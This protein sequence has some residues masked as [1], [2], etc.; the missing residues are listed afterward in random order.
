MV[1][2]IPNPTAAWNPGVSNPGVNGQNRV[3]DAFAGLMPQAFT[4]ATAV[5]G[6]ATP[7]QNLS[8]EFVTPNAYN[9]GVAFPQTYNPFGVVPTIHPFAANPFVNPS[10]S[11]ATIAQQ[12]A[13]YQNPY[14]V[15]PFLSAFSH[16]FSHPMMTGIANPMSIGFGSY[17]TIPTPISYMQP[18]IAAAFPQNLTTWPTFAGIPMF[19]PQAISSWSNP[20]IA[21]TT[22]FNVTPFQG[23]THPLTQ[24]LL[25]T[26]PNTVGTI[27]TNVLPNITPTI[28][29]IPQVGLNTCLA[30][31]NGIPQ[32][33]GY[34]PTFNPFAC[35]PWSGNPVWP[36]RHMG[37]SL[38]IPFGSSGWHLGQP[39]HFASNN[40][41][42]A[43]TINPY[44]PY[45]ANNILTNPW[46]ANAGSPYNT[47]MNPFAPN[48]PTGPTIS[49]LVGNPW[50]NGA[51]LC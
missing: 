40:P 33:L 10:F 13:A 8:A 11:P 49:S 9:P 24:T 2:T 29:A 21:P 31:P 14:F 18:Q 3:N 42:C 37:G 6:Y 50:C 4:F 44:N 39:L 25:N 5:P 27:P 19:T 51:G 15:N 34:I 26:I 32:T 28:N 38:N 48:L 20:Q 43:T 46:L 12:F 45:N 17:P 35:T 41:F 22:P 7:I 1:S 47:A 30:S 16:P 23:M 36:F